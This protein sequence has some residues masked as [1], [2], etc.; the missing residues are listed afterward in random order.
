M[1]INKAIIALAL[2]FAI[3]ACGPVKPTQTVDGRQPITCVNH[4]DKKL[5]FSYYPEKAQQWHSVD[6]DV[7]VYLIDTIDGKQIAINS[8]ELQNYT[9]K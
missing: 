3:A 1:S 7:N 6:Y 5:N 4:Q 9:C 8:L 2:G